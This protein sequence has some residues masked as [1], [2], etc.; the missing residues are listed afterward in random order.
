MREFRLDDSLLTT[1][2]RYRQLTIHKV[3]N[4]LIRN[5]ITPDSAV[6]MGYEHHLKQEQFIDEEFGTML[7]LIC[8]K[9]QYS[10]DD[11]NAIRRIL[12]NRFDEWLLEGVKHEQFYNH[13]KYDDGQLR[14]TSLKAGDEAM[15]ETNNQQFW[16][17]LTGK[18]RARNS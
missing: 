13:V 9:D 1:S 2:L 16:M 6:T 14:F 11:R 3:R 18:V 5:I 7:S 8:C 15:L 4:C 17:L 10:L 12:L